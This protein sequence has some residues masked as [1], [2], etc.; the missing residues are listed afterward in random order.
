MFFLLMWGG[1]IKFNNRRLF[2]KLE[3]EPSAKQLAECL[4]M[5][6]TLVRNSCTG[7]KHYLYSLKKGYCGTPFHRLI[8][9][10]YPHLKSTRIYS[11]LNDKATDFRKDNIECS[12]FIAKC[13]RGDKFKLTVLRNAQV[14]FATLHSDRGIL[15]DVSLYYKGFLFDPG[16]KVPDDEMKIL[17]YKKYQEAII[18]WCNYKNIG[19]EDR[20][21]RGISYKFYW[22]YRGKTYT[23]T[24]ENSAETARMGDLIKLAVCPKIR[25]YKLNFPKSTYFSSDISKVR[26]NLL[27]Y[28]GKSTTVSYYQSKLSKRSNSYGITNYSL[29]R[30]GKL[31]LKSW[32]KVIPYFACRISIPKSMLVVYPGL[33]KVLTIRC[34]YPT[35]K[36]DNRYTKDIAQHILNEKYLFKY[37]RFNFPSKKLKDF[38]L[39]EVRYIDNVLLKRLKGF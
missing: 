36:Y 38:P 21:A 37:H 15:E 13:S 19:M 22:M 18:K 8:Y 10:F 27:V 5:N 4:E 31:K 33:V 25:D 14:L 26:A 28:R 17:L 34:L 7:V 12:S 20:L 1:W 29:C 16:S 24:S 23:F 32:G 2:I 30:K 6:L 3:Y 11:Y 9:F 35:T 39:K